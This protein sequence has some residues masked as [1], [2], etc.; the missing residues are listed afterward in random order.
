MIRYI[1]TLA[2]ICSVMISS[3]AQTE[4]DT[5]TISREKQLEQEINERDSKIA[6]LDSRLNDI[7]TKER[8]KKIWGRGRFTKISYNLGST[9]DGYNPVADSKCSFSLAKGTSYLF[10]SKAIAGI[11]KFGLDI[12]WFD[13]TYSKYKSLDFLGNGWV[14]SGIPQYGYDDSEYDELTNLGRYSL[15]LGFLGFGPRVS[16][17]PFAKFN[18]SLRY[19]RASLYFNYQP[20]YSVYV[21]SENGEEEGSYTYMGMYRFGGTIHCRG[22]GFGV[23]GY[24]GESKFKLLDFEDEEIGTQA[25]K[26]NRKFANTRI[27]VQFAF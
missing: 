4:A 14:S 21:A 11:L 16:V 8:N 24:W 3:H 13:I 17:A 7:E 22:I 5:V 26:I 19:L 18:N 20:T 23:E 6:Y 15:N 12:T 25:N 9:G 1:L 27:Y 10:P 2:F